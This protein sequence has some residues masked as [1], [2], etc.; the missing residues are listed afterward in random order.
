MQKK[1]EQI[2]ES[3][4]KEVYLSLITH[5]T[6]VPFSLLLSFFKKN[7]TTFFFLSSYRFIFYLQFLFYNM[8]CFLV[9]K[10]EI[11][12]IYTICIKKINLFPGSVLQ[13]YK[14]RDNYHF[15]GN[16]FIFYAFCIYINYYTYSSPVI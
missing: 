12:E 9:T 3:V 14:S 11:I 16:Y 10:K 7:H 6:C 1:K 8:L 13:V 4:S 15:R 5:K 2:R